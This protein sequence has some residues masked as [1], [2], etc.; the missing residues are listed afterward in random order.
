MKGKEMWTK[1]IIIMLFHN[2]FLNLHLLIRCSSLSQA[3][4]FFNK[5]ELKI[6]GRHLESNPGPLA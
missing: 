6:F 1:L 5:T 3:F 4:F 2:F